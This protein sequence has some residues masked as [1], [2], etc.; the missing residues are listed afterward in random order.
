MFRRFILKHDTLFVWL[1]ALIVFLAFVVKEGIRESVKDFSSELTAAE[2][3][4]HVEDLVTALERTVIEGSNRDVLGKSLTVEASPEEFKASMDLLVHQL[5]MMNHAN[6]NSD[7]L[8]SHLRDKG[9]GFRKRYSDLLQSGEKVIIQLADVE[10]NKHGERKNPQLL[11]H[12]ESDVGRY[13]GEASAFNT[14]VF[15]RSQEELIANEH[16]LRRA[17][18]YEYILFGFGWAL[19]LA[20]KLA[21]IGDSETEGE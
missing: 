14:D 10:T 18:D 7:N 17:T 20:G 1:G 3:T 15:L 5:E 11:A 21:R 9:E 2:A 16:R 4:Y 13:W 19:G 12:L 6:E 8:A